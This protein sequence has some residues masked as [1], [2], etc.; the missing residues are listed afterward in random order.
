[1]S[2]SKVLEFRVFVAALLMETPFSE[3]IDPLVPADE[4]EEMEE[5]TEDIV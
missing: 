3:D 2:G 5:A 4:A 1:M